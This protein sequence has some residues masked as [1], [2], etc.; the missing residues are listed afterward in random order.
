MLNTIKEC[1][2]QLTLCYEQLFEIRLKVKTANSDEQKKE[3]LTIFKNKRKL[4]KDIRELRMN[5]AQIIS[6]KEEK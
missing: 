6:N 1:N 5:I 2:E 4:K 3:L